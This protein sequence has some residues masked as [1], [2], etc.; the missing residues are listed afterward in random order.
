VIATSLDCM[1]MPFIRYDTG[2]LAS[3]GP[4]GP[5]ARGRH[6]TRIARIDGRHVDAHPQA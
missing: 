2:D 5:C 4:I 1:A 3:P 6:F